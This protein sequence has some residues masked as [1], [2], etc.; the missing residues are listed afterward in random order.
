[1]FRVLVPTEPKPCQ[2]PAEVEL[3]RGSL[4]RLF[5]LGFLLT[6]RMSLRERARPGLGIFDLIRHKHHGDSAVLCAFD[7]VELDG[8]GFAPL[9]DRVSQAQASW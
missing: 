3:G 8:E 7:L 1:M 2:A 9:L 6:A 5:T 4:T